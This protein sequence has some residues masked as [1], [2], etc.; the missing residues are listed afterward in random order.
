MVAPVWHGTFNFDGQIG[1][2]CHTSRPRHTGLLTNEAF[3]Y[4]EMWSYALSYEASYLQLPM[5]INHFKFYI[6]L[7]SGF[8]TTSKQSV[9]V[10]SVLQA[11]RVQGSLG[12]GLGFR[13]EPPGLQPTLRGQFK[14]G[15]W[16]F[17]RIIT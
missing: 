12:Q 8:V 14:C 17:G 13:G 2:S 1:G 15:I 3:G 11:R 6:S 5:P 4:L 9:R 16:V 7:V 10:Y